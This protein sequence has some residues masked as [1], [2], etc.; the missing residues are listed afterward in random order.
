MFL[1]PNHKQV[2]K[3]LLQKR[4]GRRALIGCLPRKEQIGRCSLSGRKYC[5]KKK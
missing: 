4:S 2:T 1:L 3:V 5:R